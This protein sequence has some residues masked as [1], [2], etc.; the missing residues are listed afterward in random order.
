MG[1]SEN[2]TKLADCCTGNPVPPH[3]PIILGYKRGSLLFHPQNSRDSY[4]YSMEEITEMTSSLNPPHPCNA[5]SRSE[6]EKAF[7]ELYTMLPVGSLA[8][9]FRLSQAGEDRKLGPSTFKGKYLALMFVALTCPPS[10][11][12]V[13][14]W[15]ELQA[16]FS[17]AD[18]GFL[19]VYSKERHAREGIFKDYPAITS[20]EIRINHA[21][22]LALESKI[23]V[24]VDDIRE[25]TLAKYGKVPNQAILIDRKGV[26]VYK[27]AWADSNSIHHAL[28]ESLKFESN[29]HNQKQTTTTPLKTQKKA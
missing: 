16:T 26:V 28:C 22:E 3:P 10:R 23:P 12:Q 25:S 6:V 2:T 11:V 13:Q 8:P 15:N 20:Q 7:D 9:E 29:T 4:P 18:V 21:A 19:F 14:R 27:S 17:S 1:I 5:Q 24:L